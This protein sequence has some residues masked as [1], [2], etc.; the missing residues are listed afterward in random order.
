MG[1]ILQRTKANSFEYESVQRRDWLNRNQESPAPEFSNCAEFKIL[2]L[3]F[4]PLR[5]DDGPLFDDHQG[6][7]G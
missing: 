5:R 7:I 2:P 1:G 3:P 6:V 4:L